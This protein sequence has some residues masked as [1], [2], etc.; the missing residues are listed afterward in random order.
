MTR[1]SRRLLRPKCFM[2]G[3][4]NAFFTTPI[5]LRSRAIS[6]ASARLRSL[7]R[8]SFPPS[9]LRISLR[10]PPSSW[11]I[12]EVSTAHRIL[13]KA[14]DNGVAQH[15]PSA[16]GPPVMDAEAFCALDK[17]WS[18]NL[19]D[20]RRLAHAAVRN[21]IL[22]CVSGTLREFLAPAEFFWGHAH[23]LS[24]NFWRLRIG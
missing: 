14:T 6:F 23:P 10:A 20:H 11:S 21:F 7:L 22:V 3:P 13:R 4:L 5:L 8:T 17:A 24:D 18:N 19:F 2:G 12:R 16:L 15:L 1:R 9:S